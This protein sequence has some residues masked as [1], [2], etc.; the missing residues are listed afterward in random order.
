[1]VRVAVGVTAIL[2]GGGVLT[3]NVHP[4]F[5]AWAAALVSVVSGASLL[6]GLLTPIAG[7]G[8][9]VAS[10]GTLFAGRVE[11]MLIPTLTTVLAAAVIL[12]GPG[13]MS[14]DARL[15]G[16]REIIIPRSPHLPKF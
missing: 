6:A 16:R 9:L 15:F 13:A 2:Q 5:G 1:L 12:L 8:V 10:V 7:A 14:F 11:S 3:A 4:S